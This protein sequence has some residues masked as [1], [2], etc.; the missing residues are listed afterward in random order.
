MS[1]PAMGSETCFLG[2]TV[3]GNLQVLFIELHGYQEYCQGFITLSSDTR[4]CLT[5]EGDIEH[6]AWFCGR[7]VRPTVGIGIGSLVLE[8]PAT[9][10]QPSEHDLQAPIPILSVGEMPGGDKGFQSCLYGSQDLTEGWTQH[11]DQIVT[12]P[13]GLFAHTARATDRDWSIRGYKMMMEQFQRPL[14]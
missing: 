1:Y 2:F 7:M 13:K 4:L 6:H 5:Q 3:A 8:A 11:L 10:H 12:R 9:A 14:I